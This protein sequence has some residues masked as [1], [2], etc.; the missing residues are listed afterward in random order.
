MKV[1]IE[2]SATQP[3]T[4]LAAGRQVTVERTPLV[5]KMIA[6]GYVNVVAPEPKPTVADP[7]PVQHT[8]AEVER[9][10]EEAPETARLEKLL[11]GAPSKAASTAAW[12]DFLSELDPP[13]E[14]AD[15]ATRSQLI[16]LWENSGRG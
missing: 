4:F 5:A 14:F 6:R 9:V 3:N 16:E 12:K 15:D 7:V 10:V 13:I 1:T 11:T 8:M 2:G